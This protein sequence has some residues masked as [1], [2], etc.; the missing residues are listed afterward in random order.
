MTDTVISIYTV[1]Q[2]VI[3]VSG[4]VMSGNLIIQNFDTQSSEVV[5]FDPETKAKFKAIFDDGTAEN[6]VR[7]YKSDLSYIVAWLNASGLET[8]FPYAALPVNIMLRFIAE[9]MEGLP[10]HVDEFLVQTGVKAKH[11][12]H[13]VSTITRRVAAISSFHKLRGWE[14]PCA[15]DSVRML[16]QKSRRASVRRGVKIT[17]KAATTADILDM[18]L[19]TCDAS[20]IGIR[21]KA[22]ILFA[23]SSGGRRRSEISTALL[24]D[25][26]EVPNGYVYYLGKT[27]TNQDSGDTIP[28]PVVG[29]AGSAMKAWLDA[30]G[31]TEGFIF[32]AISGK[33]ELLDRGLSDKTIAR[34][35]KKRVEMAGLNP[36]HYSAHSL[37][38]GFM[39]E[40]GR[41]NMNIF[42]LMDMS[43]HKSVQVAKGYYR[44]GNILSNPAA[45]M[46][47][48]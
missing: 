2:R 27:K 6:T 18:M 24:S 47:D 40:G 34:I 19:S 26:S 39:T 31:N 35:V 15:S 4:N 7:S 11:G 42:N 22:L 9:H 16:M 38:A 41:K 23:F 5:G 14:N 28:V 21:D 45:N 8:E 17:K 44:S 30:A 12:P 48:D 37:R 10:S 33:G 36:E 46:L 3:Q 25:L 32:R 1:N 29:K 43:T 13:K 20:L